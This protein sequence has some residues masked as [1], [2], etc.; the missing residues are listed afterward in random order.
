MNE[1]APKRGPG[2]PKGYPKTGGRKPGSVNRNRTLLIQELSEQGIQPVLR[3]LELLPKV[4]EEKQLDVWIKL[5]S[6]CYPQFRQVEV[7]GQINSV[8]VTPDNVADLCRLARE[9]VTQDVIIDSDSE[10]RQ[11]L[12]DDPT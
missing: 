8:T 5:M 7:S 10:D 11:L 9:G 3:I 2:R 4:S 6:F 1:I 12:S